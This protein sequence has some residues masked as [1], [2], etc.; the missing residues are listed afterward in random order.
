MMMLRGGRSRSG[1][2]MD[3]WFII[4]DDARNAVSF[5]EEEENNQNFSIKTMAWRLCDMNV[6][7]V[8]LF[9]TVPPVH[10]IYCSAPVCFL[11]SPDSQPS[12]LLFL[13]S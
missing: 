12:S 4:W 13:M 8:F 11:N 5:L 10:L 6:D 1:R 9:P 2:W 3:D 7:F